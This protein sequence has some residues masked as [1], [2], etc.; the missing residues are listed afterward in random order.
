ML[1]WWIMKNC[2]TFKHNVII[3][4]SAPF[5]NIGC[6]KWGIEN[7]NVFSP[8]FFFTKYLHLQ[9]W[10][11][12]IL[13]LRTDT[14]EVSVSLMYHFNSIPFLK[15]GIWMQFREW[16]LFNSIPFENGRYY[17]NLMRFQRIFL[18]FTSVTFNS[19]QFHTAGMEIYF[20]FYAILQCGD[21]ISENCDNDIIQKFPALSP[22][23]SSSDTK[24][25]QESEWKANAKEGGLE[26]C[27][28]L[29]TIAHWTYDL[30]A[31]IVAH[32]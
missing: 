16:Y 1:M 12:H 5:A 11:C 10:R 8:H 2:D 27:A 31:H 21:A 30:I 9:Y 18:L 15:V 32:N 22:Q 17:F 19:M 23:L 29:W 26:D 13:K 25:Q 3:H 24:Q 7:F 6:A 14:F 20:Q 4:C 28:F